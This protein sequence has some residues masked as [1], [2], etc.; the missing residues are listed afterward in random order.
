MWECFGIQQLPYTPMMELSIGAKWMQ[1]AYPT[2]EDA[3]TIDV[4]CAAQGWQ[5]NVVMGLATFDRDAAWEQLGKVLKDEDFAN[6][7]PGGNGNSRTNS[8]YWVATRGTPAPT[9]PP[10]PAPPTPPT[11]PP[12][13]APT[14][15]PPTPPTPPTPMVPTPIPSCQCGPI[16]TCKYDPTCSQVTSPHYDGT[17]CGAAGITDCRFC[18]FGAY[19]EEK[20]SEKSLRH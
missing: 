16:T 19:I 6:T 10:T 11:L 9:M 15:V 1:A 4:N 2:F 17:G 14:Y 12:S 20:C 3:C 8:F 18:G 7:S 13:P 5:T